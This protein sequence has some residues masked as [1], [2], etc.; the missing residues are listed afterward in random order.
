MYK[1]LIILRRMLLAVYKRLAIFFMALLPVSQKKVLIV[2]F[3]G[4]GFSDN[5]KPIAEELH[6]RG[7]NFKIYWAIK[8]DI[9]KQ[10]LPEYITPIKYD[11]VKYFYHLRT[12]K[13]WLDNCRKWSY[14]KKKPAQLYI[15]TYHALPFKKVEADVSEKLSNAYVKS[16]IHDSKMCDLF[17]SNSSMMTKLYN[18][19]F[20][21]N[22]PVL[23]CGFP[24]N[25]I[26]F[27]TNKK[28]K[29]DIANKVGLTKDAKTVLYAPTFRNDGSLDHYKLDFSRIAETLKMRFGGDW[30]VLLRLHPNIAKKSNKLQFDENVTIDVTHYDDMQELLLLADVLITD[31][32]SSIL[33][34]LITNKPAFMYASD[35][36]DYN[37]ERGLYFDLE[38]L[39]FSNAINQ[40]QLA[41]NILNFD[42]NYYKQKIIKFTSKYGYKDNGVAAKAVAGWILN[43]L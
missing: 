39:P 4:R 41:D 2:S 14:I 43:K 33:D 8:E 38:E 18:N 6:R 23:E 20:W 12:S 42:N 36:S 29:K 5:L 1:Y 34:Y 17:V 19:S 32:S 25:D 11:S 13:I 7:S 35:I 28:M 37:K 9:Y 3:Y 15:N 24:R 21:Y 27:K 26:F 10:S 30:V 22:G 31:Y 16:A 40:D